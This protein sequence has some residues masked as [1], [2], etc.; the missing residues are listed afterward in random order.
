MHDELVYFL[1]PCGNT[2][3]SFSFWEWVRAND[4]DREQSLWKSDV[5]Q[6]ADDYI[7]V[8]ALLESFDIMHRV[9]DSEYIAPA[10]LAEGQANRIDARTYTES[11]LNGC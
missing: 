3:L 10:L 7:R 9:S 4:E 5:A 11:L 6:N 1:W 2:E 8:L